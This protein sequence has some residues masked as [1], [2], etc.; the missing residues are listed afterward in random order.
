M[1][2]AL[3]FLPMQKSSANA[4]FLL[5]L[6]DLIP[7]KNDFNCLLSYNELQS[8]NWLCAYKIKK[9]DGGIDG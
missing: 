9:K 7:G 6:Q 2:K 4:D 8:S 5:F 1:A 3:S